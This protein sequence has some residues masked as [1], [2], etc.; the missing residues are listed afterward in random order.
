MRAKNY[1]KWLGYGAFALGALLVGLYLTFPAEAVGQRIGYEVHKRSG[2]VL[3]LTFDDVSL[4]RLSGVAAEGVHIRAQKEGE[5][6]VKLEVD[7]LRMRLRLLPLL[8]ASVSLDAAL[9]LGDGTLEAT[10]SPGAEGAFDAEMVFDGVNLASP[11]IV[12]TLA[13]MALTGKVDGTV[14]LTW[15]KDPKKSKG[16]GSLTLTGASLGPGQVQGFSFPNVELGQ[17]DLGLKV[18]NGR[19][20]IASFK[21]QG[22]QVQLKLGGTSTL[23][24]ELEASAL[25]VCLEFKADPAFLEKNPKVK[26]ALTF[27]EVQLKKGPQGYLNV[28]L[29]GTL[30]KPRL[31]GGL[32]SRSS[33]K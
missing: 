3:S 7:A 6:P 27:A 28:P 17:L 5:S 26:T 13:G 19:F 23:R 29:S 25:D 14:N 33:A 2:G 20:Q 31:K 22:G 21:Q 8:W 32:C 24:S 18:E 15:D 1:M 9:E 12:P 10:V 16:V 30:T 4:Y 11:P